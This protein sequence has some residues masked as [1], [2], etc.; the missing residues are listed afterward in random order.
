MVQSVMTPPKTTLGGTDEMQRKPNSTMEESDTRTSL[1]AAERGRV[2]L[3]ETP[4]RPRERGDLRF[5]F[6]A[7]AQ[8]GCP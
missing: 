1:A 3:H 5:R 6:T 2:V 8:C 7:R 4:G